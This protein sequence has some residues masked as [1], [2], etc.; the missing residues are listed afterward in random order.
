MPLEL[1]HIVNSP[2]CRSNFS[3]ILFGLFFFF[4]SPGGFARER[5]IGE[6][7]P[8][9]LQLVSR[10]QLYSLSA[11]FN[12]RSRFLARIFACL[13]GL[14]DGLT[15]MTEEPEPSCHALL[16]PW[17]LYLFIYCRHWAGE[18]Q[19]M[20]HDNLGAKCHLLP[21]VTFLCVLVNLSCKHHMLLR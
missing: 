15:V 13:G 2:Q 14:P 17:P 12:L 5:L 7:Q 16:K 10:S 20:L 1:F 11:S 19:D 4:F 6:L 9:L 21:D 3:S 18:Y 8:L